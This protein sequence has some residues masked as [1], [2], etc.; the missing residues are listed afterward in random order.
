M[1]QQHNIFLTVDVDRAF[2]GHDPCE[3]ILGN[4]ISPAREVVAA[5]DVHGSVQD[6]HLRGRLAVR[7]QLREQ[8]ADPLVVGDADHPVGALVH[9][10]DADTGRSP[11]VFAKLER[12]INIL[13]GPS[14]EV[15]C[16]STR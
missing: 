14:G 2:L 1:L 13:R 10:A 16:R 8:R 15:G 7:R 4:E 6:V 5:G 3:R 11:T 9:L 12:L